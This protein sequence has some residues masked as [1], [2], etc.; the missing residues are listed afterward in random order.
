MWVS[1]KKTSR[2][3]E[4]KIV[5]LI[6]FLKLYDYDNSNGVINITQ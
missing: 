1:S 2:Y 5:I 6:I 4:R 3:I